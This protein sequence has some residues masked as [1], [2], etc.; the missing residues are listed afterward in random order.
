M[1]DIGRSG[2]WEFDR[3]LE[4]VRHT[5]ELLDRVLDDGSLPDGGAEFLADHTLPHLETARAGFHGWLRSEGADLAE[6][7][8][9]VR[10]VA[11]LR[12]E[13]PAT[14]ADRRAAVA[15]AT[16]ERALR[17][18]G[19]RPPVV[20]AAE[21]WTLAA[22]AHAR[23]VLAFIPRLPDED[24][25][26]PAGRRSYADISPPRGPAELSGRLSELEELLW[27]TATGRSPAAMDPAFRRTYGFFDVADRLGTQ[28]F[29]LA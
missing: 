21:P 4:L 25:R 9:L 26:Y 2:F 24:V 10:Q 18:A 28:P 20:R 16:A 15:E 8:Y 11:A 19:H 12:V 17:T 13:P 5:R 6:L 29:R 1:T 23:V 7:Q 3:L 22:L 27:R 14:E